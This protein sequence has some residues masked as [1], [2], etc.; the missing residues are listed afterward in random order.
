MRFDLNKGNRREI[1]VAADEALKPRGDETRLD[2]FG[3]VAGLKLWADRTG[4][5]KLLDEQWP[6]MQAAFAAFEKSKWK[7]DPAKGHLYVNRYLASLLAYSE[8]AKS[9][10]DDSAVRAAKLADETAIAL[11]AWW[12]RAAAEQ[13]A[14]AGIEGVA[15][16]DQF[17]G[18]GAG[19]FFALVPHRHKLALFKDLS[20]EVLE[21][22]KKHEP[23]APEQA[24]K[25][26]LRVAPTWYLVGEERQ[27]HYGEN[28]YDPPDFS[29]DAFRAAWLIGQANGK[30]RARFADIPWGKADLYFIEKVAM[31]LE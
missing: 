31:A 25:A 12:K 8:I 30:D 6:A 17:I 2:P 11:A 23:D 7:L 20:P 10:G 15:K 5:K 14:M 1:S 27:V 21:S 16:L 18:K 3:N 4:E 22:V 9:H 28:A 29:L 13:R 24:W 19:I 26:F